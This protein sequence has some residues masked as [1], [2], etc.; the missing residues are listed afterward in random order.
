M[1]NRCKYIIRFDD[2][3]PGMAWSKFMPLKFFLQE[4]GVKC[5]LGVVPECKDPSL[6][7]E[8]ERSDFF[9]LVR[10]YHAFGDAIAQHGTHHVYD[11]TSSGILKLVPRSEFAGHDYEKQYRRLLYGK[12]I[13]LEEKVWQPYFMA[14]SHSFDNNT[15]CALKTLGF[16]AI[17]DGRGF[18]PY[19]RA[20]VK[21]IPQLTESF[22][23]IPYG[24]QTVCFHVNGMSDMQIQTLMRFV[25]KNSGAF[26]DFHDIASLN[27]VNTFD[28]WFA[29]EGTDL[30]LKLVRRIRRGIRMLL[31]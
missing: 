17:T 30:S 2:I 18:H 19:T 24:I 1:K 21:L 14:P 15:L 5:V 8:T 28:R 11:S 10:E 4:K 7:V 12:R 13:L 22:L 16:S 26:L 9:D 6:R 23:K 25:E 3:S 29:R 31:R 27:V 20:G